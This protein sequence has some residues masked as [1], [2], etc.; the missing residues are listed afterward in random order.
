MVR[1]DGANNLISLRAAGIFGRGAGLGQ[2]FCGWSWLGDSNPYAGIFQTRPRFG[3]TVFVRMNHYL[4]TN[5]K[6]GKQQAWRAFF[7]RIMG[8]WHALSDE[9][10]YFLEHMKNWKG[11]SGWNRYARMYLRRKPTDLGNCV[12]GM[13]GLG[14]L[15]IS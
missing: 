10:K 15:T 12:L 5:P 11:M 2:M 14:N 4:Q 1:I 3:R 6:T 7:K 9:E 13:S 8:I